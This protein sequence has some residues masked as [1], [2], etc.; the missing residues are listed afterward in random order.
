MP[1]PGLLLYYL[2]LCAEELSRE[3]NI[4]YLPIGT[5]VNEFPSH[6]CQDMVI[7][8]LGAGFTPENTSNGSIHHAGA[9]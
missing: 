6:S 1:C 7:V 9:H 4:L 3:N 8:A 5:P 2:E